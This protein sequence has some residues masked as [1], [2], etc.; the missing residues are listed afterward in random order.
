[1]RGAYVAGLSVADHR[2][3]RVPLLWC[4]RAGI[5]THRVG[6]P[7]AQLT[8]DAT[9]RRSRDDRRGA[10]PPRRSLGWR[11]DACTRLARGPRRRSAARAGADR[12]TV[13]SAP[14]GP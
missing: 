13:P 14:Q 12:S 10:Q 1:L 7:L 5:A 11:H 2:P 4:A 9:S 6:L 3:A 8:T